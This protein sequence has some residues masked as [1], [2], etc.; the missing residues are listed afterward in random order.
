[1]ISYNLNSYFGQKGTGRTS[2]DKGAVVGGAPAATVVRTAAAAAAPAE[3]MMR[4]VK[5]AAA[6]IPAVKFEAA[7]FKLPTLTKL[8]PEITVPLRETI[9]PKTAT[10]LA[11]GA[12]EQLEKAKE[13]VVREAVQVIK[14]VSNAAGLMSYLE[15][16]TRV[17]EIL[18]ELAKDWEK[19][20]VGDFSTAFRMAKEK[21]KLEV[22]DSIVSIAILNDPDL[23]DELRMENTP[24]VEEGDLLENRRIV[25]QYPSAGTPLEPP[26]I[27]FAA[28]EHMDAARTED[29][30]QSIM[31]KLKEY[32]KFK[33]PA[34][35]VQK[36]G[37]TGT[38]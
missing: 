36:L 30:I 19:D 12:V 29:V 14:P 9:V 24:E 6:A 26:Y 23:E 1:M 28:V 4:P 22:M 18:N 31:G 27:I 8:R 13:S 21:P 34:S 7:A 10:Q 38:R 32:E 17:G 16:R 5:A 15:R 2:T 35:V 11:Q 3:T 33:L 25:W 20:T 37:R